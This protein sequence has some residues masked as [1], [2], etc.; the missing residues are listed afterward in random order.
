MVDHERYQTDAAELLEVKERRPEAGGGRRNDMVGL[1]KS[2][3]GEA[4]V[5]REEGAFLSKL[6]TCCFVR[7]G[8]RRGETA[9]KNT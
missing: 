4:M 8:Y 6:A 3:K 5:T 9:G 7:S 2:R 1:K